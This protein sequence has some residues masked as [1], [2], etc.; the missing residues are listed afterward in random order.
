MSADG[1]AAVIAKIKADDLHVFVLLAR[2]SVAAVVLRN[3]RA[4]ALVSLDN[5][6]LGSAGYYD[7]AAVITY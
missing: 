7:I 1:W 6:W 2:R 3:M 4:A 5:L